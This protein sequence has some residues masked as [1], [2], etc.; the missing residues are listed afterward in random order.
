M[1]NQ[2]ST[3]GIHVD[4]SQDQEDYKEMLRLLNELS[5]TFSVMPNLESGEHSV[6][7]PLEK[8]PERI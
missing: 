7:F 5:D 8:R 1:N 2:T 4:K 6:G 3:N